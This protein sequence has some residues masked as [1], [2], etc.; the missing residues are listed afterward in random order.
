MDEIEGVAAHLNDLFTC[1]MDDLPVQFFN[2][3]YWYLFAPDFQSSQP[4]YRKCL[5]STK[6]VSA[7]KCR[8]DHVSTLC[9]PNLGQDWQSHAICA[10]L[11]DGGHVYKEA[12]GKY[13]ECINDLRTSIKRC[14]EISRRNCMASKL[15]VMKSVRTSMKSVSLLM[16]ALPSLRVIHLVRDPRGV[17]LSRMRQP[18]FRGT[19]SNGSLTEEA[20]FFC[21]DVARELKLRKKLEKQYP[22]RIME[23][24]YE[25]FVQDPLD[26]SKRVYD[27]IGVPLPDYIE[28]F[29]QKNTRGKTDSVA[30]SLKWQSKLTYGNVLKIKKYCQYFYEN[31]Q[32]EWT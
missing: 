12:M 2:H 8:E 20:K 32:H 1:N 6:K 28:E 27:H 10:G 9:P 26:Y 24:I 13:R 25:K 16:Q 18:S 15:R 23:V 29:I 31:F 30:K 14:I 3:K 11:V 19:A 7:H 4:E 17:V 5:R 21:R 22:G